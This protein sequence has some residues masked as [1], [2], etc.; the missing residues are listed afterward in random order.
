LKDL[1]DRIADIMWKYR[2]WKINKQDTDAVTSQFKETC[3][4]LREGGPRYKTGLFA[5]C[6]HSSQRATISRLVEQAFLNAGI[7]LVRSEGNQANNTGKMK[8]SEHFGVVDITQGEPNSF[9]L[10]GALLSQGRPCLILVDHNDEPELPNLLEDLAAAKSDNSTNTV[11]I[12]T[13]RKTQGGGLRFLNRSDQKKETNKVETE[14][15]GELGK[16]WGPVWTE[17]LQ[18]VKKRTAFQ[19]ARNCDPGVAKEGGREA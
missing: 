7:K 3:E 14:T 19:I 4:Q 10:L 12:Y 16:D 1:S 13:Y 9:L 8:R 18:E 5:T 11:H 15:E 17:F 6:P 2:A